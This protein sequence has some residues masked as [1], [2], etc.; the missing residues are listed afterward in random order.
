MRD[1]RTQ[2]ALLGV[3]GV[4][5]DLSVLRIRPGGFFSVKV[6]WCIFNF[7]FLVRQADERA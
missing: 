1:E 6:L 5:G 7:L 2:C 4:T 3:H